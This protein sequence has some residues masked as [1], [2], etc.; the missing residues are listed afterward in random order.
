MPCGRSG[1]I[2][3]EIVSPDALTRASSR[4]LPA[5]SINRIAPG[6]TASLKRSSTAFGALASMLPLAGSTATSAACA[7]APV[8]K[9]TTQR[10]RR[11]R[12]EQAHQGFGRSFTPGAG[13]LPSCECP[14]PSA[15]ISI[16]RLTPV[17]HSWTTGKYS[18]VFGFRLSVRK[19]LMTNSS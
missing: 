18:V 1:G 4:A 15:G 3:T 9:P 11:E 8:V 14:A 10:Q 19:L 6:V 2:A 16:Q 13:D 5:P 12:G 17:S 7:D